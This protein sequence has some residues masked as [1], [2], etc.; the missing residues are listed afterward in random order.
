MRIGYLTYGLD[1]DPTGI[2]RYSVE[3]L[4]A[5][6][7][8]P[9]APEIVLLTTE[10]NDPGDMWSEFE[11]HPLPGCQ[12]LPVLMSLGN[13][14]LAQAI[15]KYELDLIHDPNGIAPFLGPAKGA[16]RLVTIHDAFPYVYPKTHTRLDNWRFRWMLPS[17]VKRADM[18]LT[19]SQ[20]SRIDLIRYLNLPEDKIRVVA[21]GVN[22]NFKPVPDSPE[23]A[24][25]LARYG[26]TS[27]Y[28][29]YIGGITPRKNIS[30]LLEAY[31]QLR[32]R[33]PDLNLV[34]GGKRQWQA[35]EI[36]TTFKR[37]GLENLVHFT[38]YVA[39]E[40]LP[41]LYSAAELFVFPSL[42][43][44]FG[45][46][47]LEAMAC[48]TPVV[49]TNVSSLPEVVGDAALLV[50]PRYNKSLVEAI[51]RGLNNKVLRA[52]LRQ[53]GLERAA[54]FSWEKA[55][56]QT[57][58]IYQEIPLKS[59]ASVS[60]NKSQKVASGVK[61][62]Y[63]GD[64]NGTTGLSRYALSLQ[65]ALTNGGFKVD[66]A[67]SGLPPLPELVF[68]GAKRLGFDLKT[69]FTTYPISL[70]SQ[71]KG[72]IL[73]LSSQNLASAAAFARKSPFI[74]TV[75]DLITI[76][77]RGNPELV[78]YLKF[79]D[80][81]FDRL[82][83]RGLKKTSLL[84]ADSEHTRQDIIKH[85]HFPAERVKVVYLGV[86]HQNFRPKEVSPEFFAR[87][88]L[89][90]GK[91]YLVYTGS[92][93]PRK[94]LLRLLQAFAQVTK[95]YP[96]VELLK[97]GAARFGEE[98]KRILDFIQ[99][100]GLADK[101]RFF[102]RV[103]DADLAS[104]YNIATVFVFPSLAEGFGLPPLEAM[105]CGTPVICS[106]ATSLPEVVGEAAL[107]ID[108]YNVTELV[109]AIEQVIGSPAL[110]ADLRQKGLERAALFTWAET[111]SAMQQ[112]YQQVWQ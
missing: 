13:W 56:S 16:K 5:L 86:D 69:F 27:P 25:I 106:N 60:Y 107:L 97:I 40:D 12:R 89:S 72:Q 108:P 78:G 68:K 4:R 65:Q 71:S 28:L 54:L 67:G 31:A 76:A 39:D 26:I 18:V 98:R 17:A 42:Y 112:I 79:Y 61:I 20:N 59:V 33:H 21:C 36:D 87:Y 9:G 2:G 74:V 103:N 100:Q 105:A 34:I 44:G 88:N 77:G 96:E 91:I 22:G 15:Q 37:L 92:E 95:R 85:L 94:N 19:D 75:H 99:T 55:A 35:G 38:G 1:R 63:G 29:L 24:Q 83:V 46:P 109:E 41:A 3:L 11:H 45:L 62:I 7:A 110:Q 8:L 82:M 48:G 84:I 57:M 30:G 70:Q 43:E 51:E 53:K 6:K 14:H 23:R 47:P 81:L 102:E 49:T 101:V 50:D 80:K 52:E 66:L 111:A 10:H 64:N 90:P 32:L 58:K 73:H 104:F 93:D